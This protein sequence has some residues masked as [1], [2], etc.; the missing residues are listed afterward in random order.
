MV[1]VEPPLVAV[2][3]ASDP[4]VQPFITVVRFVDLEGVIVLEDPSAP[5]VLADLVFVPSRDLVASE[6]TT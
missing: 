4:F 1:R 6:G 3:H 2:Q 5:V